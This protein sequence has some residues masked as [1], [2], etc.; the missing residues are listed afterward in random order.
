MKTK[1]LLLTAALS[2]AAAATS[3][4]QVYSVNAVGYVNVTLQKGFNLIANPLSNGANTLDAIL[5]VGC[6]LPADTFVVSWD[7]ALSDVGDVSDVL[8]VYGPS[9]GWEPDGPVMAP[10]KAFLLYIDAGA[11]QDTYT[12]TFVGEVMQGPLSNPVAVS[13]RW[14]A[15]ASQVPQ[16]GKVT[17][18]LGLTPATDDLLLLWDKT[19]NPPDFS[20]TI[21]AYFG[22]PPTGVWSPDGTATIEPQVGVAEGFF[23][24]RSGA[25]PAA[26]TRTFNVNP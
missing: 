25:G 3:M 8:P 22:N 16:A 13:G 4:A 21:Y 2:A 19:K 24:L 15:L 23:L 7:S 11:P 9:S 14:S 12:V 26:W 6:G 1:A 5:P 10:G 18:D 17:T 20:D